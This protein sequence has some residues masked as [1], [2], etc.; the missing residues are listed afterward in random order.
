MTNPI[1]NPPASSRT[2]MPTWQRALWSLVPIGSLGLLAWL[3]F[4][5]LALTRTRPRD[6]WLA[7]AFGAG[8][9]IEC[10]LAVAVDDEGGLGAF[11]G[12]LFIA[13]IAAAV[14]MV[15]VETRPKR[16]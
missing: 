16:L 2:N 11:A 8:T 9:V 10:V 12:L 1:L 5:Y 3:P 13:F 4:L 6:M 15:W 7:A 14:V